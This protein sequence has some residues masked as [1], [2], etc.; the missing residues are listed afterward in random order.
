MKLKY[1]KNEEQ[2]KCKR[3]TQELQ[4][5]KKSEDIFHGGEKNILAKIIQKR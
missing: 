5:T 4:K 2:K 3:R 1:R